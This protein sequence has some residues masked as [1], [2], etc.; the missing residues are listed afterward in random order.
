MGQPKAFTTVLVWTN[1]V[2]TLIFIG[3]ATAKVIA[4]GPALYIADTWNRFDLFIVIVSI[5]GCVFDLMGGDHAE[6]LPINPTI[7]RI[8]R[9]LRVAR[10]LK[11]LKNAKNLCLLLNGVRRSVPQV[12]NLCIL[13][14]L[15]FFIFSALGIELF[16]RL[17]CTEANPCD[18]LSEHAH[19]ESFGIAMLTLF[20]VAT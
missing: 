10:I 15:V 14:L 16:G 2:F 6:N 20:R 5:V 9:I 1:V 19:F 8:L 18:G 13:L 11:L 3:E 12:G 4:D 7:L 17:S